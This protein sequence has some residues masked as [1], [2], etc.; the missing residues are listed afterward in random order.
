[1][2]SDAPGV[3]YTN[4]KS[5]CVFGEMLVGKPILAGDS[6]TKQLDIIFDLVGTPTESTMPGWRS[7]PGAEGLSPR[8]RPPTISQRFRE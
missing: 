3:L 6:D 7:L 2:E 1:V 8:A 5:S 4:Y